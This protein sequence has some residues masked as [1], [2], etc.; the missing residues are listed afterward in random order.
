M[1]EKISQ[2][3]SQ[4]KMF[5]LALKAWDKAYAPYSKFNVGACILSESG[6]FHTGCNIENAAYPQGCCA[7]M[8]AI[9]HMIGA[10]DHLIQ[11]ILVLGGSTINTTKINGKDSSTESDN[12]PLCTPCGGCRQKIR[13]F[14]NSSTVIHVAT[15]KGD[16]S[17]FSLNELLPFSFGPDNLI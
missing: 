12:E 8:A 9:A 7:E 16:I 4:K 2:T 3:I 10:G 13:E 1:S 15:L 14:A 5:Q 6:S 17:S 11:E